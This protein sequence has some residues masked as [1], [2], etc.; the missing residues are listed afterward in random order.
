[1]Q[2]STANLSNYILEELSN[3]K[4]KAEV[5]A[6]LA[7]R[8]HDEQLIESMIKDSMQQLAIRR[9]TKGMAL[10]MVGAFIC[11]LSCVTTILSGSADHSSFTLI[12][13][14]SLGIMVVFAGLMMI[15]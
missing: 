1:M 5:A 7:S 15:F 11:L 6:E 3:G 2:V 14:T 12:G 4:N 9:R 13:L 8:G 10:V